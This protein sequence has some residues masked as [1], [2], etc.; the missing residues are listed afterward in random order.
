MSLLTVDEREKL[1]EEVAFYMNGN[2]VKLTK[3]IPKRHFIRI[4]SDAIPEEY[5]QNVLTYCEMSA[6]VEDPALIIQ[7][8]T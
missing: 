2:P 5:A 4:K 1:R 6:W 3:V 8:L 7:L